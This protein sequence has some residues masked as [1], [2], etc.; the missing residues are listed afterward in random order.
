M[1]LV[2]TQEMQLVEPTHL[3]DMQVAMVDHLVGK[4]VLDMAALE[5]LQQ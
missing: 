5:E 2:V 4:V 1:H 3:V